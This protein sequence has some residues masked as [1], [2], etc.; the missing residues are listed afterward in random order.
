MAAPISA[1]TESA[2]RAMADADALRMARALGERRVPALVIDMSPRPQRQ[3]AELAAAMRASYRAL[4]RADAKRLS[5]TV[6]AALSEQ[7]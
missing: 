4:P 6:A 1:S 3:L 5:A 2:D 7:R